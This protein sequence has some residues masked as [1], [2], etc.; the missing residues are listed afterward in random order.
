M[1]FTAFF[2]YSHP[3]Y[4]KFLGFPDYFRIEL[5]IAK[6]TGA[7]F[8]L[9]SGVPLRVKEWI[10]AGFGI[11]MILALIAHICRHDEL[12]R[13]IMVCIEFILVITAVN[14]VSRR[15]YE[16]PGN[17]CYSLFTARLNK[18]ELNLQVIKTTN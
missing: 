13:I 16:S 2:S 5:V 10:Y 14:Y 9:I 6:V 12:Y 8:L 3:E 4:L 17:N 1:L 7:I 18:S 15:D 11:V